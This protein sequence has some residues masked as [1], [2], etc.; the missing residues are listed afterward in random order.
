M[1]NLFYNI[2]EKLPRLGPGNNPS[3]QKA[4]NILKSTGKL[5]HFLNVLDIGCGTGIHSIQLAKLIDGRI[6]SIDNHQPFLD[7]L[8]GRLQPEGVA[9]K[10]SCLKGD[11]T[12][13]DFKKE[14][15]DIIWAEGSIFVVGLEKG[16][17]EWWTLLKPNGF[18]ALTDIFWFKPN[19][20]RELKDYF[21]Q[22]HCHMMDL[23]EASSVIATCGF[24]ILDSFILPENAWWDDYYDPLEYQLAEFRKTHSGNAGS[25]GLIDT[26]QKEIDL[27]RHY[28]EYYGYNFFILEKIET[29]SGS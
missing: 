28:S 29:Q 26:L 17:K 24:K 10:I 6:T 23:E 4:F 7:K 5:P 25:V 3:T 18:I 1:D 13:M 27:Y 20:P 2:F 15:F 12:A 9:D 14:S 8:I 19:P 21:D 16:L 22:Q 11:M